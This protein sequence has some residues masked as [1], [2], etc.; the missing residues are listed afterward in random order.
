M[1]AGNTITSLVRYKLDN[2]AHLKLSLDKPIIKLQIFGL[3]AA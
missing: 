1:L 3:L 2:I